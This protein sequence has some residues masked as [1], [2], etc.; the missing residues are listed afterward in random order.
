MC[1]ECSFYCL[2]SRSA[3]S[4]CGHEVV[5][6]SWSLPKILNHRMGNCLGLDF[7]L[8]RDLNRFAET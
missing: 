7:G 6:L 3:M 4:N 8:H 2:E 1:R 5:E